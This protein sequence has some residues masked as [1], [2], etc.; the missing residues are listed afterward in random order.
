MLTFEPSLV[1]LVICHSVADRFLWGIV[2]QQTV[3]SF[4]FL[5]P[6]RNGG[7]R[8]QNG[9]NTVMIDRFFAN[10][11]ISVDTA[12]FKRIPSGEAYLTS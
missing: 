8:V 10:P 11:E 4:H 1:G 2:G 5:R 7:A 3:S 9:H 6:L 12:I